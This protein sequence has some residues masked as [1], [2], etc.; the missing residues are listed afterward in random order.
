MKRFQPLLLGLLAVGIFASP[1]ARAEEVDTF[2]DRPK[3]AITFG[4][5][6]VYVHVNGALGAW[7]VELEAERAGAKIV[8]VEGGEGVYANAP[9]YDPKALQGGRIV[10]AGFSLEEKLPTGRVKVA[11][12]HLQEMGG[13]ARF[14]SRLIVAADA[15]GKKLNA[16]LSVTRPQ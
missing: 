1:W 5:L 6:D 9:F 11:T 15:E 13:N 3:A 16:D 12:V 2:E 8:G 4:T 7:Q 10:L 14:E